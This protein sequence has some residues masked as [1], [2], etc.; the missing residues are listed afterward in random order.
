MSI[1]ADIVASAADRLG[2]Q[3]Q[4]SLWHSSDRIGRQLTLVHACLLPKPT[5]SFD[6]INS[7][8]FPPRAFI[9]R[10]VRGAVMHATERDRELIARFAAQRA[11]LDVPEMMRIRW[12]AAADEARLLS[13]E[14]Q[15]LAIS[16][17]ARCGE[18]QDALINSFALI[19]PGLGCLR[20]VLYHYCK[21]SI[22]CAHRVLGWRPEGQCQI[23]FARR[24]P[25]GA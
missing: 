24:P 4:T 18:R 9:G 16:I 17:A 7:G 21:W 2:I 13:D 10:A 22:A 15:M 19:A 1:S 11:W 8:C 12:L 20:L 14:A 3:I 6:G 23:A 25:R 5:S